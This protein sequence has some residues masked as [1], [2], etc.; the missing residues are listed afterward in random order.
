M[1]CRMG[2]RND[3]IS[4]RSAVYM[5]LFDVIIL[6]GVVLLVAL[7]LRSIFAKGK[8]GGCCGSCAGCSMSC[9]RKKSEK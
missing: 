4:D 2:V 6:C 7:A 9:A 5:N 3:S 1:R 8:K